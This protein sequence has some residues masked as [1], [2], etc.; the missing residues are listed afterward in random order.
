MEG[1]SP[2][3]LL[4]VRFSLG[5]AGLGGLG[6]APTPAQEPSMD[7]ATLFP[8]PFPVF[9]V[10]RESLKNNLEDTL[11]LLFDPGES[12]SGFLIDGRIGTSA[13][14]IRP[15]CYCDKPVCAKCTPHFG[16]GDWEGSAHDL[17]SLPQR[18]AD[19]G[20]VHDHGAPN[21]WWRDTYTGQDLRIWWY[22]SVGRNVHACFPPRRSLRHHLKSLAAFIERERES[23]R[24]QHIRTKAL[25]LLEDSPRLAALAR[26]AD[27][28][29][30]ADL[31]EV[32]EDRVCLRH[33]VRAVQS[34]LDEHKI[35]SP[36]FTL[37]A[38]IE[39]GLKRR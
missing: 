23:L 38:R 14:T 5:Y 29:T 24:L 1:V 3:F 32:L 17:L 33:T 10:E 9:P 16:P 35:G 37:S 34:V 7:S 6:R 22:K 31:M 12:V 4:G 26:E 25:A 36:R 19:T 28:E 27:A 8:A 18:W 15:H 21:V 30:L 13:L 39:Q 2:A 20:Y 11:G